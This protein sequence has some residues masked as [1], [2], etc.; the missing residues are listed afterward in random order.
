MASSLGRLVLQANGSATPRFPNP[1]RTRRSVS[2]TPQD[3]RR[4]RDAQARYT[5]SLRCG[6]A[7]EKALDP[8]VCVHSGRT[9]T[10]LH[11]RADAAIGA[12]LDGGSPAKRARTYG[13]YDVPHK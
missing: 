11:G 2:V 4:T 10:A 12:W 5:D 7:D 13:S 3:K 6:L 9:R 8:A 1:P